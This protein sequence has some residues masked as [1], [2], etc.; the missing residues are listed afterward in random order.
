MITLVAHDAGGAEILSSFARRQR[1]AFLYV[2]GG[3]ARKIFERKLGSVDVL[4]LETAIPQSSSIICGTSWQSDLELH[5][6]KLALAM[7]IRSSAFLDH[8]VCYR[9]RFERSGSLCLPDELWVGD[10]LAE[11]MAR[12]IFPDLPVQ[13]IE[14]PYFQDIRE[15]L[16]AIHARRPVVTDRIVVLYVSGP[17]S[18]QALVQHGDARYWGYTEKE[19]LHYFLTNVSILGKPIER[20]LIRPHPAETVDKYD[21]AKS[22]FDLPIET[23]GKRSLIEEISDSDVVVGFDSMAMVI[24]L[25]AGK[26]VIS[27]VPPQGASCGLPHPEIEHLQE[28]LRKFAP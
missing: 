14:N 28:I 9:E 4:P 5:A 22:E 11:K 2:L 15:E 18:E 12:N 26:R 23:G 8:W 6:I 17:L 3:P 21:W 13:F 24:G 25:F 16:A 27:C 19:A 20:I 7:G 10:F 1:M